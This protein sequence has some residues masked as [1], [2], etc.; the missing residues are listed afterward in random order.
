M[1]IY[2]N[3]KKISII[4]LIHI[5]IEIE[6]ATCHLYCIGSR[7][8]NT[9]GKEKYYL[10]GHMTPTRSLFKK[11]I[12]IHAQKKNNQRVAPDDPH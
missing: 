10:S 4:E 6:Q 3:N 5:D 11:L 2:A 12:C 1:S 8:E 7:K 9:K